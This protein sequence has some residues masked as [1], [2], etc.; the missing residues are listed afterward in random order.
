MENPFPIKW[1]EVIH[2]DKDEEKHTADVKTDEG[3]T[4]EFQHSPFKPE[5]RRNRNNFYKKIVWVADGLR[6]E[7]DKPKLDKVL[8]EGGVISTDNFRFS[9]A[10]LP[11]DSRILREWM[12]SK[13]PVFF[14]LN[15]SF[16]WF[17]LPI[18]LNDTVYL[19]QAE[20]DFFIE[21]QTSNGFEDFLKF[22]YT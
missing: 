3:W 9:Y 21:A 13:V 17:L 11:E 8:G 19:R 16:L 15:E 10:Y 1:Q 20:N 14:N 4:I 12:N 5:E 18:V 22:V 2:R 7:K 6:R